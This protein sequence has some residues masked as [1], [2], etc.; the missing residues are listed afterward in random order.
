MHPWIESRPNET[1]VL[2]GAGASQP[3]V[4]LALGLKDKVVA[5]LDLRMN[6]ENKRQDLWKAIRPE[7]EKIDGDIEYLYQAIETLTYQQQDPTRHW[8]YGFKKFGN[9]DDSP[10]GGEEFSRDADFLRSMIVQTAYGIIRESSFGASLD[11]FASMLKSELRGIITLN[12]DTLIERAAAQN[13]VLVSTGAEEWDAGHRWKFPTDALPLLKLHGSVNWRLS[14]AHIA[15]WGIPRVGLYEL[16]EDQHAAPNGRIDA[17]LIFGGGNKLR[18]DGPW[19]ALYAAFEDLLDDA[20]TL[21]IVGY[22]FR[23]VHVDAAI[24]RWVAKDGQRKIINIDPYPQPGPLLDSSIGDLRY[25]LDPDYVAVELPPLESQPQK[26]YRY[27]LV[28]NALAY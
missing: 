20:S 26:N 2:L 13:S 1:V 3:Y 19:P 24:R 21:V 16:E 9:Y 5:E 11:H 14:R 17:P 7:I 15:F 25:A 6:G 4:P 22:S 28:K 8:T 12:Y 23:D 27:D 18:P 10:E